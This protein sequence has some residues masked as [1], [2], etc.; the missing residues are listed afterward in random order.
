MQYVSLLKILM[1]HIPIC[2]FVWSGGLP[3]IVS[4][5]SSSTDSPQNIANGFAKYFSSSFSGPL[6][7]DYTDVNLDSLNVLSLYSITGSK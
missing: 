5:G 3:S 6:Y 4:Y 1:I 2:I 7:S